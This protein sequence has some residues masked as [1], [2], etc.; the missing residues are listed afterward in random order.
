V[1]L[2]TVIAEVVSAGLEIENVRQRSQQILANYRTAFDG[3]S[4]LDLMLIDGI[5]MEPVTARLPAKGRSR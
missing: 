1:N 5:V 4:D 3:F 2:S